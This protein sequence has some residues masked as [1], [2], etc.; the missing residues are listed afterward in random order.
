MPQMAPMWWTLLMIYS[1]I[2]LMITIILN[3][4]NYKKPI[5]IKTKISIKKF[6]WMW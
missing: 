5:E 1:M 4:F 2:M 6:N 3:Y